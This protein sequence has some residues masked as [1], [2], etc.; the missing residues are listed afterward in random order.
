MLLPILASAPFPS[1][2]GSPT[3]TVKSVIWDIVFFSIT[4]KKMIPDGAWDHNKDPIER[5]EEKALDR[6]PVFMDTKASGIV[7]TQEN[8]DA[9]RQASTISGQTGNDTVAE[10]FSAEV[11][12]AAEEREQANHIDRQSPGKLQQIE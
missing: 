12:P 8:E 1:P 2:G 10:T 7:R 11:F 3:F 4:G 5:A 6:V 9:Q